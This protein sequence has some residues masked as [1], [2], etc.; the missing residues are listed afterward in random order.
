MV[1]PRRPIHAASPGGGSTPHRSAAT[2][3]AHH[4][5]C[6]VVRRGGGLVRL[7]GAVDAPDAAALARR[8]AGV[9]PEAVLE[10]LECRVSG[11]GKRERERERT[12]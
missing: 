9:K 5:C 1:L 8:V 6:S 3:L 10:G 11:R 4:R 2:T 12:I 7:G